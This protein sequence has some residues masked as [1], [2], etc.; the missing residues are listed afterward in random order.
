MWTAS[1]PCQ[2]VSLSVGVDLR[3]FAPS[4][5]A[6]LSRRRT[7]ELRDQPS[8]ILRPVPLVSGCCMWVRRAVYDEAGGF[9]ERYFILKTLIYH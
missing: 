5:Y 8:E 3:A 2:G 9:D 6:P 7:V 4:G 1:R